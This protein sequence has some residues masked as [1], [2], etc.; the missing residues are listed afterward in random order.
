MSGA[1][2]VLYPSAAAPQA[3]A[4]AAAAAVAPSETPAAP[5]VARSVA[6]ALYGEPGPAVEPVAAPVSPAAAVYAD[7]TVWGE[8]Y[9]NLQEGAAQPLDYR[10]DVPADIRD[11]SPEGRAGEQAARQALAGMGVGATIAAALHEAV[12]AAARSP[13]TTTPEQALQDLR[14]TWGSQTDANLA[15]A[16]AAFADYRTRDPAGAALLER[17]G[18]TND[19][20][21][22]RKIASAAGRIAGRGR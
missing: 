9:V 6:D 16:K 17:T 13:I 15:A 3:P 18:L 10:L 20:A 19:P 4:P 22:I 2:S 1:A 12:V 21:F 5:V 14:A 7:H 11:D 8:T